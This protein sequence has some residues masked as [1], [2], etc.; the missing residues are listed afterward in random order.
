MKLALC[1]EY[2]IDQHGG[3]EVLVSE[4]IRGLGNKHQ[5]LLVSP[6]DDDA[7][8]NSGAA[9]LVTEHISWQP[10]LISTRQSRSLAERMAR[11]RPD[12]AHF[13]FGG[14]YAWG[15]RFFRQ[16]PIVHL[17]QLH[18]PCLSTNHGAFSMVDGYCGSRR[19]WWLK[20]AL[21]L[22]AWLSRCTMSRSTSL[23][24]LP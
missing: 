21:F 22:P 15:S 17:H 8:A 1:L 3:T 14:N 13:H 9:R 18:V 23:N 24:S 12:L 16:C 20:A 11:A 4:L 19:S 7:F 10:H 6:A 5:I 2:P